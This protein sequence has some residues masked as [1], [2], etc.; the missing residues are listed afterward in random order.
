LASMGATLN[1]VSYEY[2]ALW[3]QAVLYFVICC[4]VYRHQVVRSRSHALE[5][6]ERIGRK[7]EVVDQIRRRKTVGKKPFTV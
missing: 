3:I 2:C 5:R 1:D 6:L 4:L 7:F